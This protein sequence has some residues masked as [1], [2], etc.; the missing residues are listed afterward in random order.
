MD[1][2]SDRW[3]S[4]EEAAELV[5]ENRRLHPPVVNADMP[6][7]QAQVYIMKAAD[8]WRLYRSPDGR[9]PV[10]I[11]SA[12]GTDGPAYRTPREALDARKVEMT[13]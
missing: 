4:P 10:M 13:R 12:D 3:C 9:H 5:A 1:E 8:G 6:T 7:G 2:W 11:R